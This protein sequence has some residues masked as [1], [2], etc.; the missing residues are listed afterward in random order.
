MSKESSIIHCY[1]KIK[2]CMR[3]E[4]KVQTIQYARPWDKTE[5]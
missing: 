5:R 4:W 1:P 2:G 3:Y